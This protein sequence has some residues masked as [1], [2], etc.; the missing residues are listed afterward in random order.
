MTD[1]AVRDCKLKILIEARFSFSDLMPVI[2]KDIL[3]FHRSPPT[4]SG[5]MPSP[6]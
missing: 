5:N 2:H 1:V 4:L 3:V 6:N